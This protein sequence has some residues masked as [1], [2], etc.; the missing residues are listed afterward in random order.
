[1]WSGGVR[2]RGT[3]NGERMVS[4]AM[5]GGCRCGD[6]D[7]WYWID[8]YRRRCWIQPKSNDIEIDEIDEIDD[9]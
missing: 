9:L 5:F 2:E 4:V 6:V 1:M 8:W 3:G 7:N